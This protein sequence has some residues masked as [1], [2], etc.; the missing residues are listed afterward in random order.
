MEGI[1]KN[2]QSLHHVYVSYE[3]LHTICSER[4]LRR[5][6]EKRL[7]DVKVYEL[8]KY[9]RYNHK[10][11]K[12]PV[13]INLRDI[14]VLLNRTY[15]DFLNYVDKHPD[16]NIVQFDSVIGKIND[17]QAILTITFPKYQF[18]F[19][20]LIQKG[21]YKDVVNKIKKLF[22][23]L[24]DKFVKIVFA[25][26]ICDNGVE[27]SRFTEIEINSKGEMICKTFY[28]RPYRSTDKSSCENLHRLLRYAFPKGK[29]LDNL[30]QD[31]LDEVFSHINSYVRK[32]LDDKTPY[33]LVKKK[34]GKEFL[35]KINIKR[36]PNKKVKLKPII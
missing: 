3:I 28:T 18:Q 33:D 7:F 22:R 10:Y 13:E 24:G 27:F 35:E 5:L 23:K 6:I 8:K 25:I 36:I 32:S 15:K 34:F 17:R 19:G 14:K 26:N 2:S 21:S 11:K 16:D 1:R 12:S 9:V 20:L 31:V 30:T 4:N 29:S